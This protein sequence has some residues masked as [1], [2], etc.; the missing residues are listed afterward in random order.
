MSRRQV[1]GGLSGI[2]RAY[3]HSSFPPFGLCLSVRSKLVARAKRLRNS[4][5]ALA[6]CCLVVAQ[7]DAPAREPLTG[8]TR[9][10]LST[11][12]RLKT[13]LG[14]RGAPPPDD[15]VQRAGLPALTSNAI[16]HILAFLSADEIRLLVCASRS[17][18][19]LCADE[20]LWAGLCFQRFGVPA[21]SQGSSTLSTYGLPSFSSLFAVLS[22]FSPLQGVYSTL[23]DYPY[24]TVVVVRFEQGELIAD[25]L[26]PDLSGACARLFAIRFHHDASSGAIK[27]VTKCLNHH[28]PGSLP[29]RILGRAAEVRRVPRPRTAIPA[30]G[31]FATQVAC[32]SE[33]VLGTERGRGVLE[34]VFAKGEDQNIYGTWFGD[35]AGSGDEDEGGDQ[36]TSSEV[37]SVEGAP[38]K[39][40]AEALNRGIR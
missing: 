23:E 16:E 9:P 26:V 10:T 4:D 20:G 36:D 27:V 17:L 39:R 6:P 28:R 15:G 7:H 2:V 24:G 14:A 11:A 13:S 35:C 22:V 31:F 33:L 37:Y 29:G 25:S 21:S 8:S 34:V 3:V 32:C 18:H 19:S 38:C 30:T 1:G 40:L 12:W 5:F